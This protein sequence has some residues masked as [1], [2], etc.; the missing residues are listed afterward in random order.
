MAGRHRFSARHDLADRMTSATVGVTSQ[1][2][3]WSGDGVRLSAA[4]GAGAATTS[5]LVDRAAALPQVALERDGTGTV[6]RDEVYGLGRISV[7]GASGG[8]AYEHTDALGSVTDL[9]GSTGVP[10]A[11]SEASPYGAIRSA[12]AAVGAPADPF[13]FTGQFQDSPTG[14]YYLR[15]RQYDPSI[16]RFLST[17]PQP[18]GMADPY[19]SAY[20]Y[21]SGNPVRYTDPSGRC[22]GPLIFLAPACI[23]AAI[24]ALSYVA[25]TVGSNVVGNLIENHDP[26]HDLGRGLNLVD[27]AISGAAG[28]A[29]GP[30][31]G[32]AFGPTRIAA[33]IALGCSATFASQAAGGR[34]GDVLETGIGCIAGG[35][36][37]IFLLASKARSFIYGTVVALAQALTTNAEQQSV[38]G[39]G[40]G[41]GSSVTSGGGGK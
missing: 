21:V 10:L 31:G 30:L 9:T 2:Y 18:G 13:G 38:A 29:G 35:A 41:R 15:A 25:S 5:F 23:G 12:G 34:T 33:G 3:T 36:G 4:T 22:L 40:L 27:A 16:G 28:V 8:I 7:V 14:L 19:V 32:I 20:G 17:D 37:S 6:L 24:G 39:R 11:W 26:F 1:A